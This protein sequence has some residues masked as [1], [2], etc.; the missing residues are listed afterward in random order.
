MITLRKR[1]ILWATSETTKMKL[2]R[3]YGLDPKRIAVIPGGV[4]LKKFTPGEKSVDEPKILMCS[5]LDK[6]KNLHEAL[7]AFSRIREP[8]SSITIIGEGP[9]GVASKKL[10]AV[11]NLKVRFTGN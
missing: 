5:R 2:I 3:F 4:D 7:L 1:A 9:E 6:R 11:L 10:A 8:P